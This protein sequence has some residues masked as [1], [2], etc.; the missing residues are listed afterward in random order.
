MINI[1][2]VVGRRA[3]QVMIMVLRRSSRSGRGRPGTRG[4]I[5]ASI[6]VLPRVSSLPRNSVGPRAHPQ[7]RTSFRSNKGVFFRR[8]QRHGCVDGLSGQRADQPIALSTPPIW[9]SPIRG[10]SVQPPVIRALFAP[11]LQKGLET[12]EKLSVGGGMVL[13]EDISCLLIPLPQ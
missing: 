13:K 1:V 11:P 8:Q 4:A 10:R 7:S 9:I 12:R 3:G 6:R 5:G 2:N